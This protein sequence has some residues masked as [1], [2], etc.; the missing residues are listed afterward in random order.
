[1]AQLSGYARPQLHVRSV[2]IARADGP[3]IAVGYRDAHIP[4]GGAVGIQLGVQSIGGK[5]D[6][7]LLMGGSA[8]LRAVAVTD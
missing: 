3:L 5:G 4:V 1:M 8:V 2:R 6:A 7:V